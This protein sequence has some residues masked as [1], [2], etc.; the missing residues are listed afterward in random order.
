[1]REEREKESVC[2]RKGSNMIIKIIPRTAGLL[3]E[4]LERDGDDE[5][6]PPLAIFFTF[7]FKEF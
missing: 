6:P 2:I 1:M 7:F 4:L 5:R 3:L